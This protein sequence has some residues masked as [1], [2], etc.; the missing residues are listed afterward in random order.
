MSY[1]QNPAPPNLPLAPE[2]YAPLYHEQLNNILRLYF[3]RLSGNLRQL[4]GANGG[5]Y[6]QLPYGNFYD[7]TDQ[8]AAS[9]TTA[10]AVTLNSS[11]LSNGVSVQNS[12]QITV[13]QSGVYNVQFSAQ[14]SNDDIAPQDIDIWFR[15]NGTDVDQ[16][17]TRFG[18]SQRKGA[19]DPYHTVGTVNLLL[20]LVANDYVQLMWRSSNT[21]ARIEA[22]SAGTSPTRP[23]IP[24]VIVTVTFVSGVV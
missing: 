15:V 2:K 7:T 6:L 23:A 8:S 1:L 21:S 24:S 20:D 5:R 16:S 10:Y 13:A 14:L 22:Y 17:N 9:T 11:S 4:L 3:N 12:S 19:G 18:L